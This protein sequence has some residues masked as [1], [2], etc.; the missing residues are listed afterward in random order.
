MA[1]RDGGLESQDAAQLML[2]GSVKTLYYA[3]LKQQHREKMTRAERMMVGEVMQL[4]FEAQTK[5]NTG[6]GS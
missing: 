4:D 6:A 5:G 2:Y 1:P 3:L